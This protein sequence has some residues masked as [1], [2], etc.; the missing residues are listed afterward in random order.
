MQLFCFDRVD[1]F[2]IMNVPINYIEQ[3]VQEIA[4]QAVDIL[5]EKIKSPTGETMRHQ[6][7]LKTRL[8]IN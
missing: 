4:E 8:C 2:S 1:L 5:M 3:P 7:I 6:R